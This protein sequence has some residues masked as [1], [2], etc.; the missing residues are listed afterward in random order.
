M[1]SDEGSSETEGVAAMCDV[2]QRPRR[3]PRMSTAAVIDIYEWRA[4]VCTVS[5][6]TLYTQPTSFPPFASSVGEIT[7]RSQTEKSFYNYSASAVL[8]VA[9]LEGDLSFEDMPPILHRTSVIIIISTCLKFIFIA[10]V[11]PVPFS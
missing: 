4:G 9:K 2:T 3:A 8:D 7:F 1:K 5:I 11:L 6:A 10:K